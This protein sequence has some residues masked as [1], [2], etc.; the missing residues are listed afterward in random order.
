MASITGTAGNDTLT[1]TAGDDDIAGE[2]G[3]DTIFGG[4]GYDQLF[5]GT[6]DD[7]LYG[8]DDSYDDFYGG[9]GNDVIFAGNADG[10]WAFGGAGDESFFGGDGS[11]M[12]QGGS[13]SDWIDGS[14]GNDTLYGGDG[15]DWVMGGAGDDSVYGGWGNDTVSGG[16]GD[17]LI[18]GQQGD[19]L[20]YGGAGSDRFEFAGGSGV[21]AVYGGDTGS[22]FDSIKFMS[23]QDMTFTFTGGETGSYFES[24]G[25]SSGT[26]EGIE[27]IE[28]ASGNDTL[29]ASGSDEGQTLSSGAGNDTLRGGAGDDTL[30]GGD[31]ADTF[32]V[33]DGFGAD[34]IFGGEGG[35]DD[36][37]V[38]LSG[39]SGGVT[40][41]YSS[42]E[43]GQGADGA[44]NT[45]NFDQIE[46]LILTDHADVV[47]ATSV[48]D[49]K[50][51]DHT[52]ISLHAGGGDDIV[53]GGRGGDTID[54][55]SGNDSIDGGYGDDTAFGGDGDDVFVGGSGNDEL[56]GGAGN[57][58]VY[59]G[60]EGDTL[61]GGDGNDTLFG[62]DGDDL[63]SGGA[64][65]DTFVIEQDGGSDVIAD[66]DTT[67]TDSDGRYNDQIDVSGLKNTDG[68]P[69]TGFDV[70]VTDD[71]Q[72]NAKLTFP[73]GETLVLQGGSP[74]QMDSAGEMYKAG[75]PC[76]AEESPILTPRGYVAAGALRAGDMVM[77]RDAGPQPILWVSA[78]HLDAARL[79]QSPHLRP[80][81]VRAEAGGQDMI[82][83]PQHGILARLPGDESAVL[84][85]AR[86]LA[87]LEGS[88]AQVMDR[89][90]S[91]TYVH[92]LLPRHHLLVSPGLVS[93]SFY[94]GPWGLRGLSAA[95]Q[96]RLCTIVPGLASLPVAQAYGGTVLRF[97]RFADLP[98]NDSA[99][100]LID[101]HDVAEPILV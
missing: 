7:T 41:T 19:D 100:R 73:E 46:K 2:D 16:D 12:V 66:F 32:V 63:L 50:F 77:T 35:T 38:D 85:R 13:G 61:A 22:D 60:I 93:E 53:V 58:T 71:G 55:G 40:I 82:V 69:V 101:E 34:A 51:G 94:P 90:T 56:F 92:V 67:D 57:D 37:K 36:D 3:N 6:G 52:G 45:I 25:G 15:S 31:G 65:D 44:G 49:G 88:R 30:F 29:D 23:A 68:S 98:R 14:G 39:L 20:L 81:R 24:G 9:D 17:D 62:G 86:H 76:F 21:D 75:I 28:T 74:A 70:V 5:G 11:E 87:R 59:G 47:D 72:G 4:D 43:S 97:A 18:Q 78:S 48:H 1:G 84:V 91:V 83:S 8:D 79:D 42:E 64:G 54:G 99:L 96:L 27:A 95:D 33:E 89:Q 80:V 10:N 26:F